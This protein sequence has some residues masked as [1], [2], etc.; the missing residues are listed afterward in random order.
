MKKARNGNENELM[1]D[2]EGTEG[3]ETR[4]RKYWSAPDPGLIAGIVLA[5]A[6]LILLAVGV[7]LWGLLALVLAAAVLVLAL[8]AGRRG[9][10][11]ALTRLSAH[12]R[13]VRARSHGQLEL[14]RLRRE[15]AELQTERNAAYQALGR[16]THAGETA[17]ARAAT[18]Q[19]D[20]VNARIEAKEAS[21][22]IL[23]S[24]TARACAPCPA[25]R[26]TVRAGPRAGAVSA[27]GRG[28]AA[29]ARAGPRAVPGAG[30]GARP[31]RSSPRA[32]APAR[33]RHGQ[34][35]QAERLEHVIG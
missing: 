6:G 27:S 22:A 7:W 35:R 28:H 11:V 17:G 29:R 5:G 31:G 10:G 34:A 2:T 3:V 20:D 32:G 30:S 26:G 18:A 9:T 12:R 8:E 25:R 1:S 21:I 16:A 23:Q 14:F 19:V 24:E 33:A 13:V 4:L 15:L